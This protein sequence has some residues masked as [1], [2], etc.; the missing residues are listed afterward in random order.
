MGWE[1]DEVP[2]ILDT[3]WRKGDAG[4]WLGL[5][6]GMLLFGG[7]SWGGIGLEVGILLQL[8][9]LGLGLQEAR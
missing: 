5:E 9:H 4:G 1:V 3:G 7:F 6:V 2:E 8:A